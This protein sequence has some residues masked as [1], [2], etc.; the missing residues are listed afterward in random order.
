LSDDILRLERV[1]WSDGF[2]GDDLEGL[3]GDGVGSIL[4]E[5]R[6]RVGGSW[7]LDGGGEGEDEVTKLSKV[8][9]R[10]EI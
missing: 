8:E 7:E 2:A 6:G 9:E 3:D 1:V 5:T 10:V 4:V